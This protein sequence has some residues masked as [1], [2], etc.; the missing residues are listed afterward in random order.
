MMVVRLRRQGDV[1]KSAAGQETPGGLGS[2]SA[3]STCG[4]L[5]DRSPTYNVGG[6]DEGALVS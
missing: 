1:S 3:G 4:R 6:W 2:E 5:R